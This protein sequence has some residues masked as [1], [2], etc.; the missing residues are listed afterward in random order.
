MRSVPTHHWARE[1]KGL[2]VSASRTVWKSLC[3]SW[4]NADFEAEFFDPALEPLRLNCWIVS[5]FEVPGA[6]IVIENTVAKQVPRDVQDG[7]GNRDCCLVGS[8]ASGES[9]VLS[10]EVSALG[11]RG[12]SCC[13]NECTLQP[14][15]SLARARGLSFSG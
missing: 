9:G 5:E 2:S 13:F 15:G 12:S 14:G 7:V 3:G 1:D 11:A 4:S 6:R 10:R 8:S